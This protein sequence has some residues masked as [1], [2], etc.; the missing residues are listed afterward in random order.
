MERPI[1]VRCFYKALS[2]NPEAMADLPFS[3]QLR[4][5]RGQFPKALEWLFKYPELLRALADDAD[6]HQRLH[7]I[8]D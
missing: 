1:K 3:T 4:Y 2:A 5:V 6:E 8:Q 7:H